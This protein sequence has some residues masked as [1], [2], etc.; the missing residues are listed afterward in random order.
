VIEVRGHG[1]GLGDHEFLGDIEHGM[2]ATWSL[3]AHK[4]IFSQDHF[5]AGAPHQSPDLATSRS[6]AAGPLGA[7][8]RKTTRLAENL[9][10]RRSYFDLPVRH[11]AMISIRMFR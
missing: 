1:G 5:L 4:L 9:I 11:F 6:L 3:S 7:H 10:G 8:R 2:V